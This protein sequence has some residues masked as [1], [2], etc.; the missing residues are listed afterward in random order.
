MLAHAGPQRVEVGLLRWWQGG[1][2]SRPE[3]V[4]KKSSPVPA[5]SRMASRAVSDS[6]R[7]VCERARVA[8]TRTC[9]VARLHPGPETVVTMPGNAHGV[10]LLADSEQGRVR[11]AVEA[12]LA[13]VTASRA[14]SAR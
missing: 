1:G 2:F 9:R 4:W 10:D 8:R 7:W 5:N 13:D 3:V 12:F 14:V 6:T 11:A